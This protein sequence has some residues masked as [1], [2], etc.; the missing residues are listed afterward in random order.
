MIVSTIYLIGL[1][2]QNGSFYHLAWI[3][4]W[5]T[6]LAD[7]LGMQLFLALG[8]VWQFIH[9]FTGVNIITTQQG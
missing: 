9:G 1:Q 2:R 6:G 5:S 4:A 3:G 7:K 8:S